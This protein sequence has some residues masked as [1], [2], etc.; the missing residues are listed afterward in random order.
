MIL[1]S[2]RLNPNPLTLCKG[3]VKY[4][5]FCSLMVFFLIHH[6]LVTILIFN[7]K[8]RLRYFMKSI[9]LTSR[10]ALKILDVKV[11]AKNVSQGARGKLLIAN[12]ISYVDVLVLFSHYPALFITSV[13]MREVP[14]LGSIVKFAGCFFVERRKAKRS[15]ETVAQELISINDKLKAGFD[16]FLFPEGTSSDGS[17]ILP[18]KPT[19]FQTA[20]ECQVS[21]IPICLIYEEGRDVIPW[22]GDMTFPDHL[23]KLC[24]ASN[25][26]AKLVE[27]KHVEPN[28]DHFQLKTIC[29]ERISNEYARH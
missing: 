18:F 12:H 1:E 4:I 22:Y 10:L 21:I 20:I 26:S 8:K 5:L 17:S 14:V 6:G 25:L 19:F 11:N 28:K 13:E 7:E 27:L 29:Y 24:L 23:F 9:Q 3:F 15:T 16:V 2:R